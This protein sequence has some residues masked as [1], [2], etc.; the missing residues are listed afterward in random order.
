M[1]LNDG[2]E[3]VTIPL[4][5]TVVVSVALDGVYPRGCPSAFRHY[6]SMF[7]MS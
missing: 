7:T 3:L 2:A 4:H 5:E 6:H 1:V